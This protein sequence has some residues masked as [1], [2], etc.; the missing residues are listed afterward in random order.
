MIISGPTNYD[1]FL[2]IF[3]KSYVFL[4]LVLSELKDTEDSVSS[5]DRALSLKAS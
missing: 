3:H 2:Y 1:I 5:L 4:S